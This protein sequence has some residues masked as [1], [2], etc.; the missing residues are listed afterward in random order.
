MSKIN[1]EIQNKQIQKLHIDIPQDL[2][3][4]LNLKSESKVQIRTPK[5]RKETTA[6]LKIETIIMIPDRE[7]FQIAIGAEYVFKFSEV[8]IDYT[9]VAEEQCIPMAQDNM[10]EILGNILVGMGY[11]KLHLVKSDDKEK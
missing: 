11:K 2:S 4:D 6:L 8:P 5:E 10:M 9:V 3:G 1:V 7:D